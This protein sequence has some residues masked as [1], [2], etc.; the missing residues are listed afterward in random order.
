LEK[1]MNFELTPAQKAIMTAAREFATKEF[2]AE[3]A[4][5]LEKKHEFPKKLY[6]KAADLGFVAPYVDQAYGGDGLGILENTLIVEEFCRVDSSIG[7]AL[8]LAALPCKFL[9]RYGTPEQKKRYLPKITSGE[10]G[11]AI[12][13]TEPDHGSDITSMD[14]VAIEKNGGYRLSGTKTF[15][16]NGTI[17]DFYTVLCQTDPKVSP[18]H[19]GLSILIVDR[20]MIGKNFQ[21]NELGEKLGIR[22]TSTAELVFDE[23][24]VP[25]DNVLG[26]AGKGFYQAMGFF[27][28]SKIEIGAQAVGLAQGA[29]DLAHQYAKKRK[30][31]DKPIASFQAIQHKFVDMH[32]KI[33]NA[34]H[35]VRKAAFKFDQGQRDHKAAAMAKYY[36]AEI[37]NQVT[38]DAMQVFGGYG[39]FQEYKVER[40]YRDAR[41]LSIYDGTSEIQKNIIGT[42]LFP[43]LG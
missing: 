16:T 9:F 12:A 26:E 23:L 25:A 4:A 27:E 21:V 35:L 40:Y 1:S 37:A 33:E 28:E 6:K 41:V 30:Q 39:Y 11:A 42:A 10:Y 19:K 14:T 43:N 5:E 29:F 15:I 2:S 13:L 18:R 3:L 24:E 7:L 20:D 31:F 17:A 22:L 32:L 34:R 8:D 38:Y 36:T